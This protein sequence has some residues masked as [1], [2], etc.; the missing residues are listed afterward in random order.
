[1]LF[2]CIAMMHELQVETREVDDIE[3]LALGGAIEQLNFPTLAGTIGR[4]M[5]ERS[6]RIVLD[7]SNVTYIG[8]T[9]LRELLEFAAYARTR[10]GDIKCVGLAPAIRDV[11]GLISKNGALD[12]YDSVLDALAAFRS[13]TAHVT[14]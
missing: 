6:A 5:H 14:A 2:S 9:Q 3:I 13:E 10:G 11:A 4:S 12:N 7:C 8:S 1:M